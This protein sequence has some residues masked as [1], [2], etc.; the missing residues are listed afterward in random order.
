MRYS[1]ILTIF[2]IVACMGAGCAVAPDRSEPPAY[3]VLRRSDPVGVDP[4]TR[5][6]VT[7]PDGSQTYTEEELVDLTLLHIVREHHL[8]TKLDVFG[9]YGAPA[10]LSASQRLDP[11][12]TLEE[13]PREHREH[14]YGAAAI[15]IAA[16]R[17]L[18]P[19]LDLQSLLMPGRKIALPDPGLF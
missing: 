10:E 18:N 7:E 16:I 1:T 4:I 13:W 5:V 2:A 6:P 19:E 14:Y 17:E 8:V 9:R 12:G 11:D 15:V 3:H